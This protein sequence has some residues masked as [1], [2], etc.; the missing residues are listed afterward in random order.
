MAHAYKS[1][2]YRY[3]RTSGVDSAQQKLSFISE[4]PYHKGVFPNNKDALALVLA[5]FLHTYKP[6]S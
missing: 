6:L 5:P 3:Y 2:E 4:S 1:P